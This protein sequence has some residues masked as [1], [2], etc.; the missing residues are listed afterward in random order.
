M[1]AIGRAPIH[2]NTSFSS[3]LMI[4]AEC[5]VA[6]RGEYLASHSRATASKLFV[7]RSARA[8]LSILRCSPGSIA[9]ARSF[10]VSSRRSR[11]LASET[12]G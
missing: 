11:A 6:H 7:A 5:D 3:R 12:S 10:R 2:G 4:F 1:S 9:L 8:S